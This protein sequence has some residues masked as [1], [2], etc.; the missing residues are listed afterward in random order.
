MHVRKIGGFILFLFVAL[1]VG[2]ASR[3][4]RPQETV[5]DWQTMETDVASPSISSVRTHS[6]A[7]ETSAFGEAEDDDKGNGDWVKEGAPHP[8]KMIDLLVFLKLRNVKQLEEKLLAVTTRFS[9]RYFGYF[10]LFLLRAVL[11]YDFF[12]S[13]LACGCRSRTRP[14][15][16]MASI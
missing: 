6:R 9:S 2:A 5:E 8:D 15:P 7:F 10:G 3:V 16:R 13:L 12:S 1:A 14:A 11:F 4:D